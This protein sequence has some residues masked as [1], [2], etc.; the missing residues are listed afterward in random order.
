M[1]KSSQHTILIGAGNAGLQILKQVQDKGS[2]LHIV[3]ILDDN[4]DLHGTELLGV[5]VV[6]DTGE[7]PRV[8]DE[9]DARKVVIAIPS[10]N[11]EQIRKMVSLCIK[12]R[13]SFKTLPSGSDIVDDTVSL[14]QIR[15]VNV[16]D[17]LRR[18]PV[19]ISTD[20]ISSMLTGSCVMVTGAGGSIGSELSLQILKFRPKKIV[21]FEV[22][23]YF[24]YELEMKLNSKFPGME[25]ISVIGDV[26]DRERVEEVIKTHAPGV[27]FHAAAYKHVPMMEKN[28]Y[29]AIKTNVLGS[30]N[31]FTAAAENG[32]S[33]VVLVST[34]KAVNPTSVMGSSKRIAEMVAQSL[35]ETY[36]DTQFIVVRFGNVL[37]SAGSVIPLFKRQIN[38]GGPVTITHKEMTR[39]FMSIPEASQLVLEAGALGQGGELF[40][41]DMGAP[42]RIVDLA[43]DLIKLSGLELDRDIEIV[44]SGL[45]PGEKLYEELLASEETTSPTGH[46][47][48][49]SFHT[50]QVSPKLLSEIASFTNAR[51]RDKASVLEFIKK[52]VPEFI[53]G[54]AQ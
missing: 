11:S 16:E 19:E 33:K 39:Y 1:A 12:H 46:E 18:A 52:L 32:V 10:A 47:K 29:E 13:L 17:L 43:T 48:V 35:S 28:P 14:S 53:S 36:G 24:L 37:G 15:E 9:F 7:L 6:G 54:G 41:L 23:E 42:V 20:N 2:G 38:A 5:P 49:R 21:L 31:V 25:I 34:D 45:R 44:Y 30:K 27:V 50:R 8:S 22:C 26:R 3:C 51:T 40:I 4:K